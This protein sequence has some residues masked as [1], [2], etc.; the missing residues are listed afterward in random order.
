[1]SIGTIIASRLLFSGMLCHVELLK[2]DVSEELIPSIS[3]VDK[4]RQARNNVSSN[5]HL[6]YDAKEY[7]CCYPDD[8]SDTIP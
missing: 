2:T 7:C 4:N 1:M 3:R 6:K 5:Q 8:G